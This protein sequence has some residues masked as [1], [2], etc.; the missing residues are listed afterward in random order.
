MR[1]KD[2]FEIRCKHTDWKIIDKQENKDYVCTKYG[3]R[4][5]GYHICYC[6]EHC[7]SYEPI[8]EEEE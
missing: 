1:D 7:Q 2:G 6:D 4:M 5:N 8:K 3:S